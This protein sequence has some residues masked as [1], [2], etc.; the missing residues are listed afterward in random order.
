M[1][2]FNGNMALYNF[3]TGNFDY[4]SNEKFSL[5]ELLTY[6]SESNTIRIRYSNIEESNLETALPMISILGVEK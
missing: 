2:L 6:I 5:M 4:I 1:K 3:K